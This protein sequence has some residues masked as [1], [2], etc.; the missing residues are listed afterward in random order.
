MGLAYDRKSLM[1]ILK[2]SCSSR[3]FSRNWFRLNYYDLILS[4]GI[5]FYGHSKLFSSVFT[6]TSDVVHHEFSVSRGKLRLASPVS[7]SWY[8][9]NYTTVCQ[10][11]ANTTVVH[12]F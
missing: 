3:G 9:E 11:E 1:L 6:L 7:T 5:F 12:D 8:E 2:S 4:A 10:S